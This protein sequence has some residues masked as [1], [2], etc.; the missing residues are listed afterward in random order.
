MLSI[1]QNSLNGVGI[2]SFLCPAGCEDL[3]DVPA[4]SGPLSS[5][6]KYSKEKE[7]LCLLSSRRTESQ[8]GCKHKSQRRVCVELGDPALKSVFLILENVAQID[9]FKQGLVQLS[10]T[11]VVIAFNLCPFF[12]CQT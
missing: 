2:I 8:E 3:V 10:S 9:N 6:L 11:E 4:L 1:K 7:P 12:S 5:K